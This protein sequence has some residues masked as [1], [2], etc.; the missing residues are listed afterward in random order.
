[1][2]EQ[3]VL[4]G[5]STSTYQRCPQWWYFEYIEQRRRPPRLQMAR[6]LAAHEA[7]ERDLRHKLATGEHLP[8][9]QVIED[10]MDLFVEYARETPDQQGQDTKADVFRRGVL[11]MEAW[12]DDVAPTIEPLYVEYNGQFEI[13]GIAYNWT[14]DL[15]D[16][17]RT[18]RDWKFAKR[19]PQP[20]S[21]FGPDYTLP[22]R[23]YAIGLRLELGDEEP[24][25]QIDYMVC[26]LN[27]YLVS[28]T[29]PSL[30]QDDIDEFRD[31]VVDVHD[32]IMEG[33]FPPLGL[34][35][36][37]CSWCPFA[38]GTCEPHRRKSLADE[39]RYREDHGDEEPPPDLN[40][41]LV[42]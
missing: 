22:M 29:Y 17:A 26:T 12:C 42:A 16:T 38:D 25:L 23:G 19:K 18:V 11:A 7:V 31:A 41:A 2:A 3:L 8:R 32:R 15:V 34:G 20:G 21:G 40:E 1:M 13:D 24:G 33:R 30:T 10:F 35:N 39:Y 9:E 37:A 4:S 36:N 14:A 6:G 27:P 28:V 5:S